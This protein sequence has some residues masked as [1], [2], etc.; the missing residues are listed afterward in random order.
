MIEFVYERDFE[1]VHK[2]EKS[3]KDILSAIADDYDKEALSLTL[4]FGDDD[5]L[6]D[7]NQKF[8]NHDYFTDIITFDYSEHSVLS[9]DLCISVDRV[10]DNAKEH[11]VS[12]ETELFRVVIH[13]ALHLCGLNDKSEE[14]KTEMRLTEN[15]YLSLINLN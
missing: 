10:C 6:L 1:W 14:Q 7:I 5:W 9:G 12:R 2:H 3:I 13:G 15:K 11:N 4:V 8:L